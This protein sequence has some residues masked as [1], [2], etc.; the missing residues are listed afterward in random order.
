MLE[1]EKIRILA[2]SESWR[3]AEIPNDVVR[4]NNY[5]IYRQDREGKRK[6][7]GLCIYIH[8]KLKVNTLEYSHLNHRNKDIEALILNVQQK[9]T[10]SFNVVATYRP[11]RV[12]K[13]G[14]YNHLKK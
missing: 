3:S 11:P 6:G 13:Q 10:K 8:K 7:G 2:L 14:M 5:K 4:I 12:T 9:Y 1:N